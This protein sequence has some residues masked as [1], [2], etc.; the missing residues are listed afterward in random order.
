MTSTPKDT[1][2]SDMEDLI[3]GDDPSG[4]VTIRKVIL[5]LL[6]TLLYLILS[7]TS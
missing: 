3:I 1:N 4:V 2:T 6:P 7:T 5:T